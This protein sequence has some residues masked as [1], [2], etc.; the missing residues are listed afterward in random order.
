MVSPGGLHSTL[1]W[2]IPIKKDFYDQILWDMMYH[3]ITFW[4]VLKHYKCMKALKNLTS[5]NVLFLKLA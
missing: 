1:F 4:K 3:F 2:K 5:L